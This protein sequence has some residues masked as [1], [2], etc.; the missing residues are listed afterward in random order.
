M[1]I[2]GLVAERPLETQRNVGEPPK[3]QM[4]VLV[5]RP[6]PACWVDPLSCLVPSLGRADETALKYRRQTG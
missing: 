1:D 6:L 4:P 3:R 5:T 2:R